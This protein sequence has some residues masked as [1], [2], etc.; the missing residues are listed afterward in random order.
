L[1]DADEP[2]LGVAAA[3]GLT[4]GVD[5]VFSATASDAEGLAADGSS[6][7]VAGRGIPGV[8]DAVRSDPPRRSAASFF[9]PV[10][11]DPVGFFAIP[12]FFL[13]RFCSGYG[14]A[15]DR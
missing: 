7:G 14:S 6:R 11:L 2:L 12:V 15:G 8:V 3:P 4:V 5:A 1:A 13:Q 9:D 10:C